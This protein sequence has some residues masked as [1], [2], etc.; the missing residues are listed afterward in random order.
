MTGKIRGAVV[1]AGAAPPQ[2]GR[3]QASQAGHSRT[4]RPGARHR[5][6]RVERDPGESS[7]DVELLKEKISI[8]EDGIFIGVEHLFIKENQFTEARNYYINDSLVAQDFELVKY[9]PVFKGVLMDEAE[10]AWFYGPLG[11]EK[12]SELE[13]SH[14][15]FDSKIPLPAFRVKITD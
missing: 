6:G 2:T 9:A 5:P 1:L 4:L 15:A 14:E 8:P 13:L 11:W 3:V 12:I 7:I 10:D